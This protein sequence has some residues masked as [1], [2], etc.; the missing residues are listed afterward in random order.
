[1]SCQYNLRAPGLAR[2]GEV[3]TLHRI[4]PLLDQLYTDTLRIDPAARRVARARGFDNDSD[5]FY[6]AMHAAY[7]PVTP[8]LGALLYMLVRA[9]RALRVVEFGTS[10]GISTLFLAAALRDNG[11]GF[12]LTTELLVTKADRAREHLQAA[13]LADLVEIRVGD[14]L[15]TLESQPADFIFLDGPKNL[16]LPVLTLL[17]PRLS[18]GALIVSD[19]SDFTSARPLSRSCAC[20]VE[21]LC[22]VERVDRGVGHSTRL[23][24]EPAGL[25]EPALTLSQAAILPRLS[26]RRVFARACGGIAAQGSMR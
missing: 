15:Q 10:F 26:F 21:R 25:T 22:R 3:N 12:L 19:N 18:S 23:P 5:G 2:I 9:S 6:E 11:G 4:K 20:S 16:Y 7:M 13:G 14:A 1:M 8:D 17:E 24:R